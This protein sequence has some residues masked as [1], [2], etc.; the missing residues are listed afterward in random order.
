MKFEFPQ[1]TILR[2]S[3]RVSNYGPENPY[4]C[5]FKSCCYDGK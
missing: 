3:E 4:H 2:R 5:T 1:M